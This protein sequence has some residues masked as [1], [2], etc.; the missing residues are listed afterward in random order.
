MDTDRRTVLGGIAATAAASS[1]ATPVFAKAKRP[2][3]VGV[4]GSGWFGKLNLFAVMQVAPVTPLALCDIDSV[5]L[6]EA[7]DLVMARP[8]SVVKP[9][10]PPALY[11]DYR[12]MLAKHR[13]DIVIIGTPDHW[14]TLPA[15]AA[16]ES[17]AHL[18][19]EK[20]V[21]VDI[22]EGQALV[23][24]ARKHKRTVQVGTQRRTTR[25]L[26]DAKAR[27]VDGGLL[28]KVGLAEV[29][30]YY[31]QRPKSFPPVSAPPATLDWNVY[32]GP[33]PLLAYREKIHPRN[34]RAFMEFCNG[35]MGDVGVH[36]IDVCRFLLDLG[37]PS[38]ISSAGGILVDTASPATVPDTQ[39]A[40]FRFD[41][42]LM[43]WT[44][45]QYG[46]SGNPATPWGATLY[47]DKG[48]LRLSP[49]SYEF[50]PEA[51]DG[52]KLSAQLDRELGEFPADTA[53]KALFAITRDNM[54]DFLSALEHGTR[55]AS[56][57]EQ[58][59]IST[60]CCILAN[61]SLT[62][63][64]TLHWDAAAQRVIGDEEANALLARPYRA[65]WVHPQGMA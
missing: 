5:M 26:K 24:A 23:A 2:Y 54:R 13:F 62:L 10:T 63:G 40:S 19:L 25:F 45:R 21:C 38:E 16:M 7:R 18:Y 61:M 47:G 64:R 1:L 8:D 31:R 49:N 53:D 57:I 48:T 33:A 46:A 36:F 20:P 44:N 14:H 35:Y 27:V 55:P 43:T 28:G 42:L 6:Q 41:D 9:Q 52:E 11:A 17:G 51:K 30:C 22:A 50:T 56:D 59:F 3:R 34:W 15:I 65:P 37:W 32:C 60:S 58:G 29:F 12:E 39:T 4:I